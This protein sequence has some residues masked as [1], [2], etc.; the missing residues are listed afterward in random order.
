VELSS[1]ISMESDVKTKKNAKTNRGLLHIRE[2]LRIIL[3]ASLK[4][5]IIYL[6]SMEMLED[7][8]GGKYPPSEYVVSFFRL[9]VYEIQRNFP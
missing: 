7:L 9:M 2:F 1:H 6:Y 5:K 4:K 3:G 8:P